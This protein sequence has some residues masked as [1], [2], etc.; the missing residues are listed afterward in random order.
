[1]T[2]E[3]EQYILHHIDEEGAYLSKLVRDTNLKTTKP[4]MCSGHLQGRILKML[5]QLVNPR[6]I[7]EL[8]TFTGYSALCMAEALADVPEAE[9]HTIDIDDEMAEFTSTVFENSDFAGKIHFHIGDALQVIPTIDRVFDVVF[10]DANK[11]IYSEYYNLVFDKVR[12]G[13]LIIADN[14]LWDGKVVQHP[15]PKDAQSVGIMN[16]ND[17][18]ASDTRVEKVILP[19]RDGMTLIRKK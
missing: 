11:R 19:L 14:T 16:F 4:R 6:Y 3:L 9:L 17:R 2:E 1:M 10:I 7:L 8:G 12:S 5:C 15:L 18:I 13:G